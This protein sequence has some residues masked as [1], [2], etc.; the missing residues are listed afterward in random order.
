MLTQMILNY[1]SILKCF[2]RLKSY[3]VIDYSTLLNSFAKEWR[4]EKK[5][6]IQR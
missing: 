1:H 6:F 3:C 4:P 5:S 2:L